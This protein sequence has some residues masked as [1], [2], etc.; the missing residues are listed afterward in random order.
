[1]EK[2]GRGK[3]GGLKGENRTHTKAT[4]VPV[5]QSIEKKSIDSNL[6]T[7]MAADVMMVWCG[8]EKEGGGHGERVG[9]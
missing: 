7:R 4:A 9:V 3:G 5:M 1:M 6:T 2:G 8:V